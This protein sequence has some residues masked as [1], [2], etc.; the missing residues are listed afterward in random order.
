MS[1]VITKGSKKG[2][3]TSNLESVYR[4]CAKETRLWSQGISIDTPCDHSLVSSTILIFAFLNKFF[5]AIIYSL[6]I[7]LQ[8]TAASASSALLKTRNSLMIGQIYLKFCM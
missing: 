5:V 4:D 6:K 2:Q 1:S 8:S 7:P 3:E